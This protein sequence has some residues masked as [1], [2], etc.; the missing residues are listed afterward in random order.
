MKFND[1]HPQ[2]RITA[3]TAFTFILAIGAP[4]TFGVEKPETSP[5]VFVT[6]YISELAAIE[7]IRESGERELKEDTKAN[8]SS[9]AIHSS[10]LFQLELRS[11]IKMLQGMRL[12]PPFDQLIPEIT[13]FYQQKVLI[14]Q[15]IISVSSAFLDG[16]KPGVDYG[17]LGAEMPQLR[18]RLEF[19]DKA[20]FEASPSIFAT[21]IDMKPDSKNHVSHLIITKEERAKLLDD[22]NT[23]FGSK[24][25]EKEQNW[26][27][28]AASVLK[29]YLLK[30]F[31][32]SDEPWD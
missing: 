22:I 9:E 11:Q 31:K 15:R 17:K 10:A 24:L 2:L 25:D 23:D 27:V 14:W 29:G 19:I 4:S 21:L 18:A 28:S 30:D 7:N 13:A 6:E 8:V 32:S 16:P 20:L 1:I 3:I 26:I 5:L 12:K